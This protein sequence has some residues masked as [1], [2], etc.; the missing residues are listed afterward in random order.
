M[1]DRDALIRA[2]IAAPEND[3]PRLVFADWL[4]EHGEP[5]RAEF[6]RLQCELGQV[7]EFGPRWRALR[8][9]AEKLLGPNRE[10]WSQELAGRKLLNVEF[11]RGFVGEATVSSDAGQPPPGGAAVPAA[12]AVAVGGVRSP[13]IQPL[14]ARGD[15]AGTA[16]PP[17]AAA[18]PGPVGRRQSSSASGNGLVMSPVW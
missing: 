12:L 10:K 6:I 15:A 7:E 17:G 9:R 16:A 14:L 18:P 1:T 13:R 3:L 4:E 2:V 5:T 8:E 11:R